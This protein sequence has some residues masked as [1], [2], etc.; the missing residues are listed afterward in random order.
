VGAEVMQRAFG[1]RGEVVLSLIVALATLTSINA[2]MLV[3]ARTNYALGR[4]WPAL[5]FMSGWNAARGVPVR[6]FLVQAVLSLGLVA[7]GAFQK[8]GFSAMVEFTAPVFWFFFMLTGVA[9]FVL[10]FREPHVARPFK[11]PGYPILPIVFV[12]TCGYLFYSSVT[13]A[14]SQQAV[15]VALGVMAAGAVAWIL[16]RLLGRAE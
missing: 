9:L 11:V 4:D 8:D 7:F 12:L 6:A 10:R 16:M 5:T 13:Y 1:E 15:H 2:T 3:G 14:Q